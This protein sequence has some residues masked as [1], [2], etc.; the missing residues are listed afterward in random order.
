[1]ELL[2]LRPDRFAFEFARRGEPVVDRFPLPDHN[3][4]AAVFANDV[5]PDAPPLRGSASVENRQPRP[6]LGFRA[7]FGHRSDERVVALFGRPLATRRPGPGRFPHV[8]A[9][10]VV[11]QFVVR[12]VESVVQGDDARPIGRGVD[13]HFR[14]RVRIRIA[15]RGIVGADGARRK[16]LVLVDDDRLLEFENHRVRIVV[17]VV[18]VVVEDVVEMAGV[19]DRRHGLHARRPIP[20]EAISSAQFAIVIQSFDDIVQ[21]TSQRSSPLFAQAPRT[22]RGGRFASNVVVIRSSRLLRQFLLVV[23]DFRSDVRGN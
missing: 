21:I 4:V 8:V 6:D 9:G 15:H 12:V 1:M 11:A 17:D 18:I 7:K 23:V 19:A 20:T 2:N 5:Q 10:R 22:I 3:M 14:N 16:A 13:R